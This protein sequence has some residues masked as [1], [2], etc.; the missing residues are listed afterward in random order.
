MHLHTSLECLLPATLHHFH[1]SF[2]PPSH[3]S[4]WRACVRV[5][6]SQ[7]RYNSGGGI[8]ETGSSSYWGSKALSDSLVEKHS[9]CQAVTAPRL[10]Q[11]SLQPLYLSTRHC[12]DPSPRLGEF[13]TGPHVYI[14]EVT[15]IH[16]FFSK[17]SSL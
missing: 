1:P 7:E 16:V 3:L 8:S 12:E 9:L 11:Y 14:H 17:H 13:S 2:S 15:Y 4:R 10:A 6:I 5:R